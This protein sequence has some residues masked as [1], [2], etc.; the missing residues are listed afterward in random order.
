LDVA[1]RFANGNATQEELAAARDA[2]WAA[3]RDAA[4]AAC[5]AARDA[6][7]DACAAARDAQK[8]KLIEIIEKGI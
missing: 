7:R 4:W 1:E 6:A 2:A 5:A 8:N 3:A